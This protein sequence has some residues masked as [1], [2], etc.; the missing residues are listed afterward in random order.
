LQQQDLRR[1]TKYPS[2]AGKELVNG[3]ID[4]LDEDYNPLPCGSE[5]EIALKDI[6]LMKGYL[7][8][9]E[10]TKNKYSAGYYLTNEISAI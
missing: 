5:G 7:N 10:S 3:S 9:N 6:P 2:T 4:I 1:L 8:D